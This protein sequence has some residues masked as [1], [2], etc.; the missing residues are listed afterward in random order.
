MFSFSNFK[1]LSWRSEDVATHF[2]CMF[3]CTCISKK[4]CFI[5]FN[6][7][8]P[9][10]LFMGIMENCLHNLK[11]P[12][13]IPKIFNVWFQLSAIARPLNIEHLFFNFQSTSMCRAIMPITRS[14]LYLPDPNRLNWP[15]ESFFCETFGCLFPSLSVQRRINARKN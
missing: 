12:K 2:I 11:V 1:I 13:N 4:D 6:Q 14:S 8:F 5:R 15:A 9:N 3:M 7:D 10:S